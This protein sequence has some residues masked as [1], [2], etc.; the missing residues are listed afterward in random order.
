[1][2][3]ELKRELPAIGRF[4][5]LSPVPGFRRWLSGAIDDLAKTHDF[6]DGRRDLHDLIDG[7]VS[8]TAVVPLQDSLMR[9]AAHY[10]LGENRDREPLDPVARFH[11]RNGARLER[12][13]WLG[14]RSQRG[15][16][17]SFGI[18]ANYLYDPHT[19]EKKHETYIED[20]QMVAAAR[21]TRLL[22][23]ELRGG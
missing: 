2:V 6:G 11:R 19:I 10:L 1:V 15:L 23:R 22:P 14:D 8:E 21:V 5:T 13:N 7:P 9:P 4:A 18:M 12:L 20:H 17:E 16:G 3:V